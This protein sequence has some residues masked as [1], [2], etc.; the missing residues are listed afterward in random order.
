[1]RIT[2]TIAFRL[3][4]LIAAVQAIVLALLTFAVIRVQDANLTEN[5]IASAGRL[6]DMVCRSTLYS[7]MLNRKEDVQGIVTGVSGLPGIEGI[8]I[9]NK[10]GSVVFATKPQDVGQKV[11]MNAEACNICH[12][13]EGLTPP[14][15]GNE[16]LIRIF[17]RGDGQRILGQITPIRNAQ[18]CSDADCHAHP[19]EKTILGVLDVKMSLGTVDRQLTES[20]QQLFLMSILAVLAISVISWGFIWIE[21]RRPVKRLMAGMELVAS[22]DLNAQLPAHTKDE[23]GRLAHTFNGM[24]GDLARAREEITAW[25]QT[26]EQKVREKTADLERAHR[27]MVKVEKMASLGNLASSVAHELNNPL[28]GIV[29]FARLLIKR[30]N[31]LPLTPEQAGPMVDDLKLV[32]DEALR[33][34]GIVKNLLVFARQRGVEFQQVP[35]G[36]IIDRCVLLMNHHAAIHS[37]KLTSSCTFDGAVECDPNQVQQVL[38]A[39]M[40]NAIEAMGASNDRSEGGTLTLGVRQGPTAGTV[41]VTVADTGVGMSDEIKAHI[42]EPFFTTKSEGKG[43]G[44]GL[45]VAYGIIERHHGTID[46]DS[47]PGRGTTF[48]MTLPVTQPSKTE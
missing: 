5:M 31:K 4:V 48:I 32:A 16:H 42:F 27:E 9:Y 41:V 20:R 7:M 23:F 36:P 44:L 10:I 18:Q 39:L 47:A 2:N 1:M 14:H 13:S 37:V 35:L 28:E 26:L 30:T 15:P 6:S 45:P 25:S 46:V 29:T 19:P 43:V 3:F 22:G 34:G 21:V 24:T 33:C 8:R 17:S 12:S 11:D 40:V 38:I